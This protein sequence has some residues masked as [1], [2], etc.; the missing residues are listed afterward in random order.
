[1]SRSS[2]ELDIGWQNV[3]RK[4]EDKKKKKKLGIKPRGTVFQYENNAE[5]F[6][7]VFHDSSGHP[8]NSLK[9]RKGGYRPCTGHWLVTEQ[10]LTADPRGHTDPRSVGCAQD[11]AGSSLDSLARLFLCPPCCSN[12]KHPLPAVLPCNGKG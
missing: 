5:L 8:E 6:C 9:N 3:K 7:P 2:F 1:M 10:S 11:F 12:G 4:R